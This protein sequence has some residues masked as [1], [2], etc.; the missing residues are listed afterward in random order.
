MKE[1]DT[2]YKSACRMCH[3]GCGVDVYVKD[4]RVVQIKGDPDSPL[5]RGKLCIKGLASIEHLYHPHRLKTPLK[6]T[7][8]RGHGKWQPISWEEAFG[9]IVEQIERIRDNY[10]IESIAIGQGTG[11]HHFNH[12]VRFANALG[13]PNWFEPGT[14][15]CFIPRILTGIMTYG[16]LPI[17]DYYGEKNPAC[18]VVWGHN[19]TV[20]GPDGELQFR[21]RDCIKRGTKL[22]VIDPRKTDLAKKADIWL[23]IRPGTDDAL[24]LSMLHFIIKEKLY[25]KEFVEKWTVGFDQLRERVKEHTP[26]WAEPITWIPAASIKQAARKFAKTKPGVLEW[27]CA[28]EHTPNCL[29][30]VRAISLLPGITGNIDVPGGMILGKNLIQ[31]ANI[32]GNNLSTEMKNKRLGAENYRVL[33]SRKSFFPSAHIPTVLKAI[34]TGKP[35]PVKGF[36]AFGANSL[37][38]CGNSKQVYESLMQL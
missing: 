20:S 4:K 1:Y 19:P 12:V 11:R 35:Y 3:G 5:N 18:V 25:D 8:K 21:I 27:G 29:Q 7:G 34:R 14:A 38:S 15:Q 10:G 24:A 37:I 6:R 30:T 16:G 32:L 2:L 9:D 17:C 36:M 26:E 33:S 28:L 13:T 23:R 31:E 22:I